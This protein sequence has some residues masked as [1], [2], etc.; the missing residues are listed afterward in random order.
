MERDKRRTAE[1]SSACTNKAA[2]EA[3][4]I[5]PRSAAIISETNLEVTQ[6]CRS[7]QIRR[8]DNQTAFRSRRGDLWTY[9]DNGEDAEA[10]EDVGVLVAPLGDHV[11]LFDAQIVAAPRE[12]GEEAD[13]LLLRRQRRGHELAQAQREVDGSDEQRHQARIQEAAV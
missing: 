9:G 4:L 5:R 8:L 11:L 2:T 3:R 10:D 1:S 7:I 13:D 6:H 12:V